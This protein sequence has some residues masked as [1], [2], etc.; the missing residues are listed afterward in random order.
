[1]AT[2][3]AEAESGAT[4]TGSAPH[5]GRVHDCP[6]CTFFEFDSGPDAQ[7]VKRGWCRRNA[8]SPVQS[9]SGGR[10]GA[11]PRVHSGDWCG[12]YVQADD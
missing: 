1:M 5:T 10:D 2:K 9:T 11:W 12:E 7:G 8:P 3:Q 6:R 4:G